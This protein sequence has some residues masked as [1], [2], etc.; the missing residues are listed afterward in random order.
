MI[1]T[2]TLINNARVLYTF[3]LVLLKLAS[4]YTM[5]CVIYSSIQKFT[6]M[7]MKTYLYHDNENLSLS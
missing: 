6:I 2:N 4:L 1:T 3:S 5:F 7:L